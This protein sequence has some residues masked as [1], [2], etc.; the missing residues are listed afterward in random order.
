MLGSR[1]F[2]VKSPVAKLESSLSSSFGNDAG[3]KASM[4]IRGRKIAGRHDAKGCKPVRGL[5]GGR[6]SGF[7]SAAPLDGGVEPRALG[8][9]VEVGAFRRRQSR[10]RECQRFGFSAAHV[11]DN[12]AEWLPSA[13]AGGR[14]PQRRE[15]RGALREETS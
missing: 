3:Q 5:G 10:D 11:V 4:G 15:S 6:R 14:H 13:L 9:A 8:A 2:W 7:S 12:T 1:S